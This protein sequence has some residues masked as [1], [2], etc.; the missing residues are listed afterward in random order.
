MWSAAPCSGTR[1]AVTWTTRRARSD[2]VGQQEVGVKETCLPWVEWREARVAE[3]FEQRS[4]PGSKR[5][6]TRGAV[7][8]AEAGH[9]LVESRNGIQIAHLEPHGRDP[10][11][12]GSDVEERVRDVHGGSSVNRCDRERVPAAGSRVQARLR[13]SAKAPSPSTAWMM[14]VT[15]QNAGRSQPPP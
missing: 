5:G 14:R 13:V 1:A 9:C 4:A 2:R 12:R 11:W 8:L 15:A 10:Q 6:A 3:E 7:D